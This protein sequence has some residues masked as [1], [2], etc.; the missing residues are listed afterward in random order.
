LATRPQECSGKRDHHDTT[1]GA[2]PQGTS[3]IAGRST[4]AQNPRSQ[5]GHRLHVIHATVQR[6]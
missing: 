3:T 5:I 6:L 4:F 2:P 1:G